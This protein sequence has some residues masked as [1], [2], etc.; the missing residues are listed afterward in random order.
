[1]ASTLKSANRLSISRYFLKAITTQK[2]ENRRT[3]IKSKNK[4]KQ[5]KRM[6]KE[7][8]EEEKEEIHQMLP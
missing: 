3:E 1:M 5:K 8:L 2:G 4:K 7:Y 6:E